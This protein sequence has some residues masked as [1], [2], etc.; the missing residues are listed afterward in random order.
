MSNS[1]IGKAAKVATLNIASKETKIATSVWPSLNGT[2]L[3]LIEL[4]ISPT[5]AQDFLASLT[6]TIEKHWAQLPPQNAP[7]D[8]LLE[9]LLANLNF[10]LESKKRL[11]GN[12]LAPR[13][14][15]AVA[16]LQDNNLTLSAV[17][18]INALLVSE[19]KINNIINQNGQPN[20]KPTFEQITSGQLEP[21]D[22][23]ILASTCLLDYFSI[24]KLQKILNSQNPGA[25]L[26]EIEKYMDQLP[27]PAPLG[28]IALRFGGLT[29][30]PNSTVTTAPSLDKLMNT[31]STTSKLLKPKLW[32]YLKN[33]LL[34]GLTSK[35]IL[36]SKL[37]NLKPKEIPATDNPIINPT[38]PIKQVIPAVRQ[39]GSL[40]EQYK[41]FNKKLQK[42]LAKLAW[43]TSRQ[44]AKDTLA[45]WLGLKIK[46]WR[47]LTLSKKIIFVL[48]V[49]LLTAFSTSIISLG[50]DRLNLKDSELY[51]QLVTTITEQQAG[52]EAALIYHDDDKAAD[53]LKEVEEL[54]NKLPRNSS[55]RQA[56]YLALNEHLNN[57]KNRLQRKADLTNLKKISQLPKEQNWLGLTFRQDSILTYNQSG[58][59]YNIDNQ[60]KTTKLADLPNDLTGLKNGYLSYDNGPIIFQ[61]NNDRLALFNNPKNPASLINNSPKITSGAWYENKFYF[62]DDTTKTIFR[63]LPQGTNLNASRW[64]R[65]SEAAINQAT[66]LSVD[67]SIYVITENSLKKYHAGLL[68][69]FAVQS[70]TPPLQNLSKIH[71]QANSDYI[72]LLSQS[73]KRLIIINK[74]G[75]LVIQ[76][77]FPELNNLQDFTLDSVNQVIYLL[78]NDGSVYKIELAS[79]LN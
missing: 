8:E 73:D 65:A 75:Q 5:L 35:K 79:Y 2:L 19:D 30:S 33:K 12:P 45:D 68:N 74:Q 76:L 56:Q 25:A 72:F 42:S 26:R 37:D 15:L 38:P 69:D 70:I 20:A 39:V 62:L 21:D 32:D 28:I 40:S 48:A 49:V 13:Y 61:G 24:A 11:M 52:L 16:L 17:G 41:N 6:Q 29:I 31:E 60:G 34:N 43:L 59:L 53:Y 71:T 10:V 36:L 78:S 50:R 77:Y 58:Q 22:S 57:L 3:V 9:K 55:S 64:L 47:R 7:A 46:T 18:R 1:A 23:F 44:T 67:G 51:N 14:H 63:S 4:N 27:H 54:L 66:G